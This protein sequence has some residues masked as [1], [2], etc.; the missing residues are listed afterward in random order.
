MSQAQA[1]AT[2][3]PRNVRLPGHELTLEETLRVMD[4]AREMRDRRE[5]AEELFRRDD[6]RRSLREKLLKTAQLS[7]DRVT[8][9]E[10]DAAIDQYFA[11][12]HTYED[13]KFGWRSVVAHLWVW[14]NELM[15]A[16]AATALA[17]GAFTYLFADTIAVPPGAKPTSVVA[18]GAESVA[19]DR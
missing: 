18:V 16:V 3:T 14:R 9:A 5:S 7:G 12:L 2:Q 13:P 19:G 1:Q 11:K 15:A 10:L 6:I 8:E 17:L 4:V